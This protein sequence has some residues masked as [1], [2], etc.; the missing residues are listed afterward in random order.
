MG[1]PMAQPEHIEVECLTDESGTGYAV[2]FYVGKH[3]VYSKWTRLASAE[4][5]ARTLRA[6]FPAEPGTAGVNLPDGSQ[7]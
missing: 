2:S 7:P 4:K 3:K 5:L 1:V 6:A